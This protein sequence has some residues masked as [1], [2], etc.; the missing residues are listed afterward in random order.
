MKVITSPAAPAAIGPY[1]LGRIVNG[2]AFLSGQLPIDP[3]VGKITTEDVSEQ[4]KQCLKNVCALLEAAGTTTDNVV[5]T[6]VFIT[7]MT[8]FPLV[9]E[10]YKTFFNE[11]FPARSVFAVKQ[12]PMG[13]LVE[14]ECIVAVP[15]D[16]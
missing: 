15:Q 6:T 9:N 10:V 4:A 12:L 2:F 5:K 8:H 14:V 11:P 16:K 13:A 3:S 7:D 1:S